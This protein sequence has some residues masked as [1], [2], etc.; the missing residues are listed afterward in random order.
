MVSPVDIAAR[1][2]PYLFFTLAALREISVRSNARIKLHAELAYFDG[3]ASKKFVTGPSN[4]PAD[5]CAG[6]RCAARRPIPH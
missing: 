6:E 4:R 5:A 2:T 1:E 3:R